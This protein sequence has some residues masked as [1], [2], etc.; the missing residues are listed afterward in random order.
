[1]NED[2]VTAVAEQ[3]ALMRLEPYPSPGS[4]GVARQVVAAVERAGWTFTRRTPAGSEPVLE[5]SR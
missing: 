4:R 3:I 2:I 1:M 5:G